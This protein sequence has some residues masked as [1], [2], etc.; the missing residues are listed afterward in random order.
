MLSSQGSWD[1]SAPGGAGYT[2][3]GTAYGPQRASVP[4]TESFMVHS[5]HKHTLS[6]WLYVYL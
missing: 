2:L 3:L 5:L 6:K 1:S 4:R